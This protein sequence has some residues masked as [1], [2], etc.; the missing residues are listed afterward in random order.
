MKEQTLEF[1]GEIIELMKNAQFRVRLENNHVILVHASGKMRKARI[2][3]LIGDKV[4][5]S[6]SPY[7]LALGRITFR[8]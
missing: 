6:V 3:G 7:N 1:S 4:K 8:F 5:V 2:R